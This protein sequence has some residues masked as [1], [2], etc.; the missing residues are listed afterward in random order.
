MLRHRVQK[1]MSW[2]NIILHH[3]ELYSPKDTISISDRLCGYR[4]GLLII[5]RRIHIYERVP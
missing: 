3:P 4:E 5:F 2:S 1:V